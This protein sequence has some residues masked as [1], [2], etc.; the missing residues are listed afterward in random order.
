MRLTR[1]PSGYVQFIILAPIVMKAAGSGEQTMSSSEVMQAFVGNTVV[2]EQAGGTAY[3]Y[4]QPDGTHVGMHPAQ[5]KIVGTWHVDDSGKACV[6]WKYPAGG[7]T[8]CGAIT[9][10]GGGRYQWGDQTLVVQR[11]DVKKLAR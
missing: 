1:F 10:L 7:I 3:D 5:G 8:N 2:H 11:G 9:D 4:V 6:T